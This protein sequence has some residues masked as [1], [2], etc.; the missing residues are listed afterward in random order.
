MAGK[1]ALVSGGAQGHG[2]QVAINLGQEGLHIVLAD[3][4]KEKG[5]EAV[6]AIRSGGGKAD[7]FFVD[8]RSPDS[9]HDMFMEIIAKNITPHILINHARPRFNSDNKELSIEDWDLALDVGLSGYFY[10]AR[11]IIPI[12][13]KSG[14]G[15]IINISSVL[16]NHV[17]FDQPIGYH[18]AKSG[19]TQLTRYLAV[20]GGPKGVRVNSISPAYLVRDHDIS[21]YEADSDWSSQWNWCIPLGQPGQ[22]EDLS[23]AILFLA[24]KMARLIT[25]QDI[26]IDGGITL[27][28]P[29]SLVSRFKKD[30]S[31]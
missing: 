12:M 13:E 2:L 30:F 8:L 24:S 3:I 17:C 1:T 4:D 20:W 16:S 28:E 6:E 23:N 22:S 15:N 10:C 31:I 21:K 9:V 26:V 14:G 5:N 18:V 27:N 29:G 7:F 19:V 11:E 25:G